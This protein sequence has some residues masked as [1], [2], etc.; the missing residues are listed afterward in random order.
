MPVWLDQPDLWEDV[1]VLV[2]VVEEIFHIR[3]CSVQHGCLL[4]H[5]WGMHLEQV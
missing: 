5:W 4:L 1:H 2:R 3:N